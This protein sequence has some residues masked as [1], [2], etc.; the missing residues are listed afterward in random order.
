[1]PWLDQRFDPFG[2]VSTGKILA[3]KTPNMDHRCVVLGAD[4]RDLCFDCPIGIYARQHA[5]PARA[6]SKYRYWR[7][8]D[9]FDLSQ[10]G[11]LSAWRQ[12]HLRLALGRNLSCT[13]LHQRP[14]QAHVTSAISRS[15]PV[16]YRIGLDERRSTGRNYCDSRMCRSGSCKF[17]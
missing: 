3:P 13:A 7:G 16:L 9:R 11:H 12:N 2:A 15:M 1:M 17:C 10:L 6:C 14:L 5:C 8:C 4:M